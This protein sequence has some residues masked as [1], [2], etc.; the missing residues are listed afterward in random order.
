MWIVLISWLPIIWKSLFG[1]LHQEKFSTQGCVCVC[2]LNFVH[3]VLSKR[4]LKWFV[5]TDRVL[6]WDDPRFPT[7]QGLLRRGL[8]LE[9]LKEFIIMQGAS[10]NTTLQVYTSVIDQSGCL[11]GK[12]NRNQLLYTTS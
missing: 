3:T 7:V 6:G 1:A 2:R 5:E 11:I 4:K 8:T 9:A 10:R 12:V